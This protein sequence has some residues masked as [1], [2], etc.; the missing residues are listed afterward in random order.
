MKS[1]CIGCALLSFTMEPPVMAMETLTNTMQQQSMSSSHGHFRRILDEKQSSKGE[2]NN[3]QAVLGQQHRHLEE[4]DKDL[5]LL[6][7][8]ASAIYVY[9]VGLFL[10][11]LRAYIGV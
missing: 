2:E 7:F 4:E 11:L 5:P 6:I 3:P 10:S 9:I 8:V 1:T